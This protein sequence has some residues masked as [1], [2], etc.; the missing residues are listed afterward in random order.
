MW[1]R[2]LLVPTSQGCCKNYIRQCMVVALTKMESDLSSG[3]SSRKPC[4]PILDQVSLYAHKHHILLFLISA[5]I[6]NSNCDYLLSSL[7]RL[8]ALSD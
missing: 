3:T 6:L 4:Q 8:G 5:A 1:I 7:S 2:H